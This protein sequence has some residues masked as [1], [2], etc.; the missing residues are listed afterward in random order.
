M[1]SRLPLLCL[2]VCGCQL[3]P[4]RL[5]AQPGEAGLRR[6]RSRS[7][8]RWYFTHCDEGANRRRR[9]KPLKLSNQAHR[10]KLACCIAPARSTRLITPTLATTSTPSLWRRYSADAGFRSFAVATSVSG[11]NSRQPVCAALPQAASA[12]TS[13]N[14]FRVDASLS[15]FVIPAEK[16]PGQEGWRATFGTVALL[17]LLISGV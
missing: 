8:R 5:Y 10:R 11:D 7:Q 15:R 2:W 1:R 4:L 12:A 6:R 13:Q 3:G 16:C 9:L 14:L 17:E